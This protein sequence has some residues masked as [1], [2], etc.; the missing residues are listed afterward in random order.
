MDRMR[1]RVLALVCAVGVAGV[2][3]AP[4]L[5]AVAEPGLERGLLYLQM[6][7][8]E[9]ALRELERAAEA[10]ERVAAEALVLQ[11]LVLEAVGRPERAAAP[12]EEA[13]KQLAPLAGTLSVPV[14]KAFLGRSAAS[15]GRVSEAVGLYREALAQDPGL[16][17]ARLGLAEALGTQ[18]RVE[19]AIAEYREF[20]AANPVDA[21]ALAALGELYLTAGRP[22]EAQT[23][24][25]QA[26]R[27]DPGAPGAAA[28]LRRAREAGS[29]GTVNGP[30][31]NM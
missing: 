19:E 2:A 8:P 24:L 4:G 29:M 21:D 27:L 31:G 1:R 9:L 22:A 10:G 14:V 7:L 26:M 16:G 12:L 3:V 18:G 28:A 23:T 17:L 5:A 6:D 30:D 20:L 25:E 11:G 13:A 15:R